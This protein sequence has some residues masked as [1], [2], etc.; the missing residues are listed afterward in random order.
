MAQ[1]GLWKQVR[2]A[3]WCGHGEQ[4]MAK[5]RH[6]WVAHGVSEQCGGRCLGGFVEGQWED[7]WGWMW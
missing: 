5:R 3:G 6:Q 7:R 2:V 1:D 4:W